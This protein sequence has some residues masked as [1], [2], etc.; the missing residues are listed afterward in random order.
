MQVEK[1]AWCAGLVCR[2]RGH[3]HYFFDMDDAKPKDAIFAA[4]YLAR[5]Y[6][7]D[8]I[9]RET[10]NGYHLLC[11]NPMRRAT[12][13]D[14]QRWTPTDQ[15][16]DYFTLDVLKG[17]FPT[18]IHWN[19]PTGSVLRTS[20]KGE[21]PPPETIAILTRT[22]TSEKKNRVWCRFYAWLTGIVPKG[23][24]LRNSSP[25]FVYYQTGSKV[26]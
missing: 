11:P 8:I 25:V 10:G 6:R 9:V 24:K 26:L 18:R 1:R 4:E 7:C 22:S 16:Q 3:Y 12:V 5:A 17:I 19:K 13:L 2:C 15:D 23:R 14:M 20:G 21:R